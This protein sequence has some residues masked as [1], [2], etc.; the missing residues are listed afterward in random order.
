[1]NEREG[2]RQKLALPVET[3]NVNLLQ[4]MMLRESLQAAR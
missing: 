2:G 1:V 4:A 3:F